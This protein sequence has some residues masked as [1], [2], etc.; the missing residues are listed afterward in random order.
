MVVPSVLQGQVGQLQDRLVL[1]HQLV[2]V[3]V[4]LVGEKLVAL[5]LALKLD[6]SPEGTFSRYWLPSDHQAAPFWTKENLLGS[7][8]IVQLALRHFGNHAEVVRYSA[9]VVTRVR[10]CERIEVENVVLAD[11]RVQVQRF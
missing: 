3:L 5:S 7:E 2:L 9:V 1:P 10:E 11:G 4:P 8:I 6:C